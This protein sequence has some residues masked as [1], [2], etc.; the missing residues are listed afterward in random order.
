[1][2]AD[3][4]TNTYMEIMVFVKAF[5]EAYSNTVVARTSYINTEIVYGAKFKIMYH[6]DTESQK[7]I[8][9]LDKLDEIERKDLPV[10]AASVN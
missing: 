1:M 3:D 7:T 6:P 2:S 10:P 8:L 5:D 9:Q 4:V